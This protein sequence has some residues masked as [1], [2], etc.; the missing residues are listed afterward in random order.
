VY[1]H[2]HRV[3][4]G[5]QYRFGKHPQLHRYRRH[6]ESDCAHRGHQP[7]LRDQILIGETTAQAIGSRFE[8]REIDSIFIKG[9]T[10][11]TRV[12]ELLSAAGQ[13]SE[14]WVRL[15]EL[16]KQARQAYLAQEWDLA[17]ATFREC[18]QVRPDD[19]PSRVFLEHIQI[20]R[21]NPPGT[22]WNGVWQLTEK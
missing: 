7:H 12:F 3:S 11:T 2:L 19:R 22:D 16:F 21:R 13:L 10:E 20:L 6:G 15:R 17:E 14:E 18:L 5:R 8:T 4:R 9:K 1:W